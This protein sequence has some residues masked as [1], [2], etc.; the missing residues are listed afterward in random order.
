VLRRALLAALLLGALIAAPA[1]AAPKWLPPFTLTP[2]DLQE[3]FVI[4]AVA[5]DGTT[6]AT[7]NRTDSGDVIVEAARRLPGQSF[8]APVRLSDPGNDAT[9]P[10]VGIDAGGNA[11][12]VWQESL[13]SGLRVRVA[14]LPAGGSSFE[15]PQTLFAAANAAA[16]AIGVGA[17]GTAVVV[18]QEGLLGSAVLKAAIREGAGG[19][20]SLPQTMSDPSGNFYATNGTAAADVAVAPDGSAV[21]AWAT[22][23]TAESRSLVQTNVR[24]PNG[25]F[26][27]TGQTRSSTAAG[28]SGEHPSLTMDPAGNAT[29]AWTH[30]P[31]TANPDSEVRFSARPA[32]GGFGPA[33]AASAPAQIAQ[34]PDLAATGDGTVIGIWLSGSGSS[35][36]VETAVRAPG[37]SSFGAHQLLSPASGPSLEARLAVNPAGQAVVIWPETDIGG[38][39]AARRSPGGTFGDVQEVVGDSGEPSGSEFQFSNATLALDDQGNATALWRFGEIR[40]LTPFYRVQ[41][42]GFDAAPPTLSAS[43]PPTATAGA[44]VGMAA[45]A[46]DRWG[47]VSLNW[48]FGD[49]VAGTGDAVSHAFGSAG[50]FNVTVTATDA[51]GNASSATR[52]IAVAAPPPR[53]I[54]SSVSSRWGFDRRKR[55]IFLLRLRV[56][57]PP[58][59]AVA[60]LRCKGR[61]CPFR[62]K[63]VSRIRSNRIDVF[64]ALSK[65]QRRFRP[66][67]VLQLRITAPGHIGKVVRFRLR[68]GRIPNGQTLCLPPGATKPQKTC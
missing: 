42:A 44:A 28:A 6:V 10:Q 54:D 1:Q 2:E 60:E 12:V 46:L 22:L 55:F 47:P 40:L 29:V 25:V 50:A 38:L 30:I 3:P 9:A 24:A 5:P 58:Q 17:N 14:R 4:V 68:R 31:D 34:N 23:I 21:V 13:P 48:A 32:G 26:A 67:Q 53:R 43:V 11:T 36:S 59:G 18:F 7:W 20:F 66:G 27:P 63:R 51:A 19:L 15:Q 16:P 56:K 57:A 64:K 35:R 65:R 52:P 41:A 8:S 37:A 39:S 33:V 45:A 49:G 61:R 62:R